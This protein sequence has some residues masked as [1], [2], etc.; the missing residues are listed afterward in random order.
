MEYSHSEEKATHKKPGGL[1]HLR[2]HSHIHILPCNHIHHCLHIWCVWWCRYVQSPGACAGQVFPCTSCTSALVDQS[3]CC[4]R[5]ESHLFLPLCLQGDSWTLKVS[6]ELLWESHTWVTRVRYLWDVCFHDIL[7]IKKNIFIMDWFTLHF[8][9]CSTN[10]FFCFKYY[11]FVGLFRCYY[12]KGTWSWSYILKCWAMWFKEIIAEML[13]GLD[14]CSSTN[15][16]NECRIKVW[17]K[18]TKHAQLYQENGIG[19]NMNINIHSIHP[20]YNK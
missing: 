5:S 14:E 2:T 1:K 16:I 11:Q 3:C 15:C 19:K 6:M 20:I 18:R 13:T 7:C 17:W 9:M 4:C 12:K 8:P 10:N